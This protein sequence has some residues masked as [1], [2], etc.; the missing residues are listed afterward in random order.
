VQGDKEGF[1]GAIRVL[2]QSVCKVGFRDNENILCCELES[3]KL[4]HMHV[5]A[6]V[7]D[8]VVANELRIEVD[9][10]KPCLLY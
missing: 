8:C 6:R 3:S 4:D 2:F 10:W 1:G 7:R 9:D 5:M